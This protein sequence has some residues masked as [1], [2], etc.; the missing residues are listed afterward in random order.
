MAA[1]YWALAA[2]TGVVALVAGFFLG[3]G[4]A[5]TQQRLKALEQERDEA[6]AEVHRVETEVASHFEQSAHMFGRL[7]N[8]YRSFFEHFARTARNLGLSEGR[9]RELLQQ[10]DP[11]MVA[12]RP[13]TAS[14]GTGADDPQAAAGDPERA[15][16]AGSEGPVSEPLAAESGAGAADEGDARS[17]RT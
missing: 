15:A 2:F 6:R 17:G 12:E 9:A 16:D 4:S 1:E 13:G 8:D 11:R 7:A 10:A 3:R 5:P 14:P